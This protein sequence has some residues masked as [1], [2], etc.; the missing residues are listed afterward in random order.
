MGKTIA[1]ELLFI[2]AI[3]PVFFRRR[4]LSSAF[5]HNK[6]AEMAQVA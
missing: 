4:S 5:V 1:D 2:V 6:L 3:A